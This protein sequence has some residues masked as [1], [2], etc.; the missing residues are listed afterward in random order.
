MHLNNEAR[1]HVAVPTG[2]LNSSFGRDASENSP[3]PL[4]QQAA[5]IR[6][7]GD[8]GDAVARCIAEHVSGRIHGRATR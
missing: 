1:R 7:R 2:S 4:E 3:S 5:A 6:R 8:I